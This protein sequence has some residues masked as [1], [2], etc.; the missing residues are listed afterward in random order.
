M[1]EY[2]EL[3]I[4]IVYNNVLYFYMETFAYDGTYFYIICSFLILHSPMKTYILIVSYNLFHIFTFL[5]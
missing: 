3:L 4:P 1:Y 2:V 5:E